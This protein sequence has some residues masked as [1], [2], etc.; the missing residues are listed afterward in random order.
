ML[1]IKKFR[2]VF[3]RDRLPEYPLKNESAV[4]NLN[5]GSG[6]HWVAYHKNGKSVCNNSRF[7]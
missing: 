2:G 4:V 7:I 1:K 3:M 6:T 5:N